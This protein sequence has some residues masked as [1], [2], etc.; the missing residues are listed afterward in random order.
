MARDLLTTFDGN[1]DERNRMIQFNEE[2]EQKS[3]VLCQMQI[4]LKKQMN[5]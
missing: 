1:I 4:I 5:R 2:N 3:C